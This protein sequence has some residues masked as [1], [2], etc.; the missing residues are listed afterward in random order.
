MV[1]SLALIWLVLLMACGGDVDFSQPLS[2]L[3]IRARLVGQEL[4]ATSSHGARYGI[5]F[6]RAGFAQMYDGTIEYVR[7][8]AD[9]ATGLCLQQRDLPETCASVYQLNVAH[10]RWG[11][12]VFGILGVHIPGRSTGF[13]MY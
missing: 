4:E 7:W 6:Q 8:Y 11:D 3:Q 1:R 2:A 12:T 10:F 9:D 5:Y 13:P